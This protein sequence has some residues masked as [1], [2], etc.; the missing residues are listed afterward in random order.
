MNVHKLRIKIGQ[1]EF[2]A[3]GDAD[4]VKQQLEEFKAIIS[5]HRT[6]EQKLPDNDIPP[7]VPSQQPPLGIG[8]AELLSKV[9]RMEEK[10]P[11]TLSV[12]PRGDQ[13]ESDAA[14]VLLL[15]YSRARRQQEVGGA[16]LLEGLKVSGYSLDRV[17]RIMDRM[18]ETA[19]PLVLRTGVR[20]GVK[21]RLTTR[22]VTRAQVV[23][24]EMA[25]IVG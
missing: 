14:L 5:E 17:D 20:R 15:A 19:E 23:V 1:H 4:I 6:P 22:G 9:I 13:R 16:A 24:E 7:L 2:E 8:T 10:K 3:E 11:L 25:A 12:L 18:I 21:Y